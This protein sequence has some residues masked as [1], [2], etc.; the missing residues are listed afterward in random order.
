MEHLMYLIVKGVSAVYLLHKVFRFLSGRPVR[1]FWRFL[2]RGNPVKEKMPAPAQELLPYNNVVGKSQTVYL[3]ESQREKGQTLEPVFS[4]E[5]ERQPSYEEEPD[6]A[7]TDVEYRQDEEIP[8]EADRFISLDTALD[9]GG[10]S[11]GMTYEQISEAL[12]VVQGKRTDAAGRLAAAQTL[13]EVRG[14]D[15]F[16]F[17]AAQAQN[18]AL[19]EKLI[20]E[21]MDSDGGRIPQN[22]WKRKRET[23]EFD[24]DRY[25]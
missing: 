20:K 1:D 24:M 12:D 14:S 4:E 8:S 15:L 23:A 13:Y 21:N 3:E 2:M 10:S 6:V 9:D 19:V 5:M 18:E 17:L 25:V 16:D 11:T 22:R 7:D